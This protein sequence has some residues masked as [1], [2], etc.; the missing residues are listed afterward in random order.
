MLRS[1]E[2]DQGSIHPLCLPVCL[3]VTPS[4]RVRGDAIDKFVMAE[5]LCRLIG[6]A[7]LHSGRT[8]QGQAKGVIVRLVGPV[9]AVGQHGR[10]EF[11]AYIGQVD[12]LMRRHLELLGLRRGPLNGADVPVVGGHLV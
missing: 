6:V 12:P 9:F 10:A 4:V 7:S 5:V 1:F 11:T 2:S 8:D 3:G